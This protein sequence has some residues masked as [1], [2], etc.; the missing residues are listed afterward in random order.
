MTKCVISM[1]L[2]Y[3]TQVIDGYHTGRPL[4]LSSRKSV[5][6]G[7]H[8]VYQCIGPFPHEC[9]LAECVISRQLGDYTQVRSGYHT[10]RPLQLSSRKSMYSVVH[11]MYQCIGPFPPEIRLA[12]CVISSQLGHYTQVIYSWLPYMP[13]PTLFFPYEQVIG[14]AC[15][16]QVHW[17]ILP[18]EQAD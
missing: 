16:V 13:T 18:G 5:Y 1:R 11:A 2:G 14:C 9:R 4:Q 15:F 8:A 6:S 7:V 3:Y 10:G 17:S 12:E